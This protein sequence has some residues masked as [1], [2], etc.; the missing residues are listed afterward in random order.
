VAKAHLTALEKYGQDSLYLTIDTAL[1]PEAM[2]AEAEHSGNQPRKVVAP[3]IQYLDE[4][5][6]LK[7]ADPRS[8]GRL[9]VLVEAPELVAE[10]AG[11]VFALRAGADQ[12]PFDLAC[13]VLGID[14]FLTALAC[15]PDHPGIQVLMN[16]CYE[17][18]LAL[19]RALIKAGAHYTSSGE[20]LAGR[21]VVSPAMYERFARRLQERMVKELATDG[22]F[23][24]IH[25]CGD[26]TRILNSLSEYD[27]CGFEFDQKTEPSAR[28]RGPLCGA[29]HAVPSR[30]GRP[31]GEE[32][33]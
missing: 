3:A 23:T 33:E 29:G 24:V 14:N 11:D 15:D 22:I 7:A 17:S 31:P 1:L 19:H 5:N 12:G 28:E 4:V 8:D 26:T 30:P 32:R 25:I 16:V 20:S 6:R 2:G 21:D 13:L 18:H 10:Q 27:Y 9:S